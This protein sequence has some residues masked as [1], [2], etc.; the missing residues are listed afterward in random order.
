MW[1]ISDEFHCI[2]QRTRQGS[3]ASPVNLSSV[4]FTRGPRNQSH[5]LVPT[6]ESRRTHNLEDIYPKHKLGFSSALFVTKNAW[7]NTK[8]APLCVPGFSLTKQIGKNKK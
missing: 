6:E 2:C 8:S 1:M 3:H 7:K 4:T 5:S